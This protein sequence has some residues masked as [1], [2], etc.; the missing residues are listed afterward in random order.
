MNKLN[1]IFLYIALLNFL[2]A[3]LL[4]FSSGYITKIASFI[5]LINFLI[6]MNLATKKANNV[7]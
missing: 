3:L 4:I 5:F 2:S 7:I 1:N 6:N